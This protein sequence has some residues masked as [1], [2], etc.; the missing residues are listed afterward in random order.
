M[1]IFD[2]IR[3]HMKGRPATSTPTASASLPKGTTNALT[4]SR[5]NELSRVR[6]LA[7]GSRVIRKRPRHAGLPICVPRAVRGVRGVS[8]A[9]M[10]AAIHTAAGKAV[11][12]CR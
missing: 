9:E 10:V 1:T 12:S 2:I 11:P 8:P 7:D 3:K 6:I 5:T 4:H